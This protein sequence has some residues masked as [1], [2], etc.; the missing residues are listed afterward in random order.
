MKSEEKQ[1]PYRRPVPKIKRNDQCP[2]GSGKKYKKCHING[3]AELDTL[4]PNPS[5][6]KGEGRK[7]QTCYRVVEDERMI[8]CPDCGAELKRDQMSSED[9]DE[10]QYEGEACSG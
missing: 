10:G 5:P 8:I 6:L 2:C 7:C 4:T 3:N 1:I 9:A